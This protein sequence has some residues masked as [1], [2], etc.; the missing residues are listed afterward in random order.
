M[1]SKTVWHHHRLAPG[2]SLSAATL[3]PGPHRLRINVVRANL[4]RR[5]VAVSPLHTRLTHRHRLSEL[6]KQPHLVAAT[7]GMYFN[8]SFGSPTVPLIGARGPLVLSAEHERIAGIGQDGRARDGRA[9]LVGSAVS[10]EGVR[11]RL[12]AIN[13]I[14]PPS[15]LSLYTSAWGRHPVPR[16]PFS[17]ALVVR[18]GRAIPH[19]RRHHRVPA[20]GVLLVANGLGALSWMDSLRGHSTIDLNYR[21]KSNTHHPFRQAYGVGTKVVA[22]PN[23][24]RSGLY[25][26]R[27]EIYAARTDFAWAHHGTQLILATVASPKSG[28]RAGVDENQMS[29]I[30]VDLG[31]ERSYALD[32][33]GSTDLVAR[34]G[35]HPLATRSPLP[36]GK[37]RPIP[38]G[39]G[40]FSLPKSMLPHHGKH[41]KHH[42]SGHSKHKCVLGVVLCHG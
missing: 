8:F 18:H 38:V 34:V 11:E 17:R 41:R 22:S 1:T 9:W 27:N 21:A 24:V 19:T 2:V 32:G 16:P 36:K 30:M 35:N 23:H 12:V 5:R 33:G 31:A 26:N 37:E 28:E 25:C 29:E 7:N 20:H 10:S 14:E 39:V 4:A 40:V 13:E 3:R 6:A 15:G 42:K